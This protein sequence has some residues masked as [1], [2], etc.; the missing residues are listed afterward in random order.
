MNSRVKIEAEADLLI[1]SS[2]YYTE[3]GNYFPPTL[4]VCCCCP[5]SGQTWLKMFVVSKFE[6]CQGVPK[7]C[8]CTQLSRRAMPSKIISLQAVSHVKFLPKRTLPVHADVLPRSG[9]TIL[10]PAA[11]SEPPAFHFLKY[12]PKCFRIPSPTA[13][14]VEMLHFWTA[15]PSIMEVI[16]CSPLKLYR[17]SLIQRNDVQFPGSVEAQH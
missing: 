10:A 9:P 1:E 14:E 17:P 4:G 12:W 6:C 15:L 7:S 11:E 3:L 5:N 16:L 8:Q 13:A 2:S